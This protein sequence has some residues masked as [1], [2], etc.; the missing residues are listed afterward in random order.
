M[1][2]SDARPSERVILYLNSK[3][4][5]EA[6]GAGS[7]NERNFAMSANQGKSLAVVLVPEPQLENESSS[8]WETDNDNAEESEESSEEVSEY[9][10]HAAKAERE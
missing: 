1:I 9:S 5:G 2:V 8:S 7:I 6:L 4:S 3:V 10:G